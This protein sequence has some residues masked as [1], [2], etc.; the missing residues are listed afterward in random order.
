[1]AM[2]RY[3]ETLLY[4]G[5]RVEAEGEKTSPIDDISS[6]AHYIKSNNSIASLD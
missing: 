6:I 4:I 3:N 2:I 5:K 1:M